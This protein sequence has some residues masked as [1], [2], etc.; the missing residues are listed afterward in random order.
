MQKYTKFSRDNLSSFT[1]IQGI[2]YQQD[3]IFSLLFSLTKYKTSQYLL[4]FLLEYLPKI[5]GYAKLRYRDN[6]YPISLLDK[7]FY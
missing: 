5:S 7:S 3:K 4:I 1:P 2:F 6:H